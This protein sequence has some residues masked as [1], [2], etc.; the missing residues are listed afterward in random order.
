MIAAPEVHTKRPPAE[1]SR[2]GG[3]RPSFARKRGCFELCAR[4]GTRFAAGP[5]SGAQRYG[6]M[7]RFER[8]PAGH[9]SSEV[10]AESRYKPAG[11]KSRVAAAVCMGLEIPA[12]EIFSSGHMCETTPRRGFVAGR[13]LPK[14]A[15]SESRRR[16]FAAFETRFT[17]PRCELVARSWNVMRTR[18]KFPARWPPPNATRPFF[19]IT[20]IALSPAGSIQLEVALRKP[21]SL[22]ACAVAVARADATVGVEH[23]RQLPPRPDRR[24]TPACRKL[25]VLRHDELLPPHRAGSAPNAGVTAWLMDPGGRNS[26]I[27]ARGETPGDTLFVPLDGRALAASVLPL[28]HLGVFPRLAWLHWKLCCAPGYRG[29]RCARRRA[30][31]GA[32][33]FSTA[34][35][36]RRF[37]RTIPAGARTWLAARSAAVS[38]GRWRFRRTHF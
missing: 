14:A 27:S 5:R 26:P 4:R 31:A 17:T 15:S 12:G 20:S 19:G 33:A 1:R 2:R 34:A 38:W 22:F 10:A 13:E 3:R 7:K 37:A 9:L 6:A 25:R 36:A 18:V 24:K 8:N 16:D 23:C 21:S 35:L 28:G 32:A 11:A 30:A 29:V